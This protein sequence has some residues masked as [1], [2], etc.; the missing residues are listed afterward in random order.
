MIDLAPQMLEFYTVQKPCIQEQQESGQGTTLIQAYFRLTGKNAAAHTWP[1]SWRGSVP[2]E[3][4]KQFTIK[5]G[6]EFAETVTPITSLKENDNTRWLKDFTAA[7]S[8]NKRNLISFPADTA[9]NIREEILDF[10]SPCC[11]G[12][13]K[14]LTQ[15][16]C[17]R[18]AQSREN[19][20][21]S[22]N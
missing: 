2:W 19:A 10:P 17:L 6:T 21:S 9:N 5:S 16:G 18:V 12:K 15:K 8:A 22:Q 3:R 20:L 14:S 4:H 1:R 11:F 13:N 7:T